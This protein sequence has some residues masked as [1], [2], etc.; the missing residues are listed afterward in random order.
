LGALVGIGVLM[1]GVL[2]LLAL[3][4]IEKKLPANQKSVL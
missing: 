2:V 1:T 3:P 4:A